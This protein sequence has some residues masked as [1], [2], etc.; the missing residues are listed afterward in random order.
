M[1]AR[2]LVPSR[3][4]GSRWLVQETLEGSRTGGGESRVWLAIRP[5]ASG[6]SEMKPGTVSSS[7]LV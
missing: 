2:A 4:A 5:R 3:C 1:L 6:L 7:V